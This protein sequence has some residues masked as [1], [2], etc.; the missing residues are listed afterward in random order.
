MPLQPMPGTA[1]LLPPLPHPGWSLLTGQ[2]DPRLRKAYARH[3]H[4]VR[5]A[6]WR[7]Q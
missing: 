4:A 1:L 7:A 6:P 3:Q 5:H 2:T